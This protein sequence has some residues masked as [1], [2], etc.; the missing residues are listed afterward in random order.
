MVITPPTIRPNPLPAYRPLYELKDDIWLIIN[1]GGRGGGKSY[2]VSKFGAIM[3]LQFSKRVVVLRDQQS[4]IEQSILDEIKNRYNEINEKSGNFYNK[5][6]D[7]QAR[8]LKN[9]QTGKDVIFT[10]GFQTSNVNQKANLKS[11]SDVDIAIIEEFEDI[12][13]EQKFNTFADSVRKEGSVII[14]NLNTPDI[15]HWLLKR[16]YVLEDTEYTGYFR[17]VPR[18]TLGV[19]YTFTTF[20]D[21]P[22]LSKKT[23]EKY[24]SYGDLNSDLYNL[25]YY[26]NAILGLVSEGKKGRIYKNWKSITLEEFESLPY[27]S[28]A[29]LDFGY[30]N[31]PNALIEVK[32][33]NRSLYLRKVL[34][35][36][37][38]QNSETAKVAKRD[39]RKN[40]EIYA[41]SSDP[42]SIS[43]LQMY[44]LNVWPAQKG[45]D[46]VDIGIKTIQGFNVFYVQDPDIESE[47]Q[48]YSWKLDRNGNITDVPEDAN[49]HIMDALRYAVVSD[50]GM[51]V[52]KTNN[53]LHNEN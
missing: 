34:Y 51:A 14:I 15:N 4:T 20:L 45:P 42:K 8:S 27:A 39:L 52:I 5:Y 43:E 53:G 17:A 10:K 12:R 38:M 41:D 22:H 40:T 48:Q 26:C 32:R 18:N 37:G 9:K 50:I 28:V 23:V 24:R 7:F 30:S 2:E 25:D 6:F 35:Q 47:Y 36:K 49:N 46:S 31:D 1:L 21:N 29:G 13:D 11:I 44:G 3:S 33:H 19:L 16:F